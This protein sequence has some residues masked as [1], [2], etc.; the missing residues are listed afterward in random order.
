MRSN[1][2]TGMIALRHASGK[3]RAIN[4]VTCNKRILDRL[5]DR[6]AGPIKSARS[7]ILAPRADAIRERIKSTTTA[8]ADQQRRRSNNFESTR[9]ARHSRGST[10][11]PRNP[12]ARFSLARFQARGKHP[13]NHPLAESRWQFQ[14]PR[15]TLATLRSGG[16]TSRR[17]SAAR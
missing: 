3:K 13:E 1:S 8:S 9:S 17:S 14:S 15:A 7:W 5:A 6:S 4:R 16:S 11:V 10:E 2:D 12:A